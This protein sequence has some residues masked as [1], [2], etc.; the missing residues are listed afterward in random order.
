MTRLRGSEQQTLSGI[1]QSCRHSTA[2]GGLCHR[3][4]IQRSTRRGSRGL[5]E[6]I[7]PHTPASMALIQIPRE[8]PH[9]GRS[10]IPDRAGRHAHRTRAH[11]HARTTPRRVSP[12]ISPHTTRL[13]TT[14]KHTSNNALRMQGGRAGA[15]AEGVHAASRSANANMISLTSQT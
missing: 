15:N 8:P 11:K 9:G 5:G 14:T 12:N 7:L 13:S 4:Q 2:P 3:C 1:S 6:H 10:S